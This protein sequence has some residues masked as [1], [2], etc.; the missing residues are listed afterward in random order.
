MS[1]KTAIIQTIVKKFEINAQK[2]FLIA[3]ETLCGSHKISQTSLLFL[4]FKNIQGV[5]FSSLL[6]NDSSK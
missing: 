1:D 2:I 6:Y 5:V 3:S 4:A